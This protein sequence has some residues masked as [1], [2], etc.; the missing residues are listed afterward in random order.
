MSGNVI[1]H[2]ATLSIPITYAVTIAEQC[3]GF[4]GYQALMP[5]LIQSDAF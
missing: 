3:H 1:G 2:R 5:V 4:E